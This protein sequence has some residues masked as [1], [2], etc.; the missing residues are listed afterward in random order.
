MFDGIGRGSSSSYCTV[1]RV[2]VLVHVPETMLSRHPVLTFR[3][4]DN[5][6]NDVHSGA[7]AS[8]LILKPRNGHFSFFHSSVQPLLIIGTSLPQLQ[9]MHFF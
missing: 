6:E 9:R 3:C 1:T 4:Y 5:D 7:A 2:S 8:I